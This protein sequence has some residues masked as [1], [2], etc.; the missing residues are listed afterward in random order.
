MSSFALLSLNSPSSHA[1]QAAHWHS[2]HLIGI[3]R[4]VFWSGQD[5]KILFVNIPYLWSVKCLATSKSVEPGEAYFPHFS[6]TC[7]SGGKG[8]FDVIKTLYIFISPI[9]LCDSVSVDKQH[10]NRISKHIMQQ[11][12]QQ[13]ADDEAFDKHEKSHI[14]AS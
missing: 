12:K 7:H 13:M 5:F 3:F 14:C 9:M 10:F 11:K 2:V 6:S 1:N 4:S 8:K